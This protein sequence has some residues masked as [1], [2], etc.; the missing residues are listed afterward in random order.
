MS[1]LTKKDYDGMVYWYR[2]KSD[3]HASKEIDKLGR[4]EDVDPRPNRLREIKKFAD[5]VKA[6][7]YQIAM[8][9]FYDTYK[10]YMASFNQYRQD[11]L[12]EKE[13]N[14]LKKELHK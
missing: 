1:R 11:K 9:E 5:I 8:A 14:F 7:P 13:F 3:Y 12:T 2:S 6:K 4:Y 10:E